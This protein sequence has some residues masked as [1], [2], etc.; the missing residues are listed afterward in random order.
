M[1]LVIKGKRLK[2]KKTSVMKNTLH[3]V[4]N[5][6]M[7]F[8]IPQD[9][10]EQVD[11]VVKVIDYDRVGSNELIGCIGIGP[12]FNGVGRDHW[13]R[14]LENPRK[15]ITQSY[16]L[17]DSSFLREGLPAKVEKALNSERQNSIE[18]RSIDY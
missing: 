17:R 18:S 1:T 3:P 15:P 7:L 13:Y 9:Q 5:E 12:S 16:Y 11:M 2:K 4:Y 6:S 8:D 14:M 10:I